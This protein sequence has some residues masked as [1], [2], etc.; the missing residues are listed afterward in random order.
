MTVQ[1]IFF[2]ILNRYSIRSRSVCRYRSGAIR[3][4]NS[5]HMLFLFLLKKKAHFLGNR[6]GIFIIILSNQRGPSPASVR[7]SRTAARRSGRSAWAGPLLWRVMAEWVK[8]GRLMTGH[9]PAA[10][11]GKRGR[12]GVPRSD[13][14]FS[15]PV[16]SGP[17]HRTTRRRCR[18]PLA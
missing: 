15:R 2:T 18:A 5:S 9:C 1:H 12:G 16:G 3:R 13:G 14:R 10:G 7:A 6:P 4:C 17:G 8:T 11:R